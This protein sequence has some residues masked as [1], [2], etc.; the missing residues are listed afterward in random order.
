MKF[1]EQQVAVLVAELSHADDDTINRVARILF[2][3]RKSR[4]QDKDDLLLMEMAR[5]AQGYADWFGF[6]A[7]DELITERKILPCTAAGGLADLGYATGNSPD[8][9]VERLRKKFRA[10]EPEYLHRAAMLSLIV[11]S[12]KMWDWLPESERT[13]L[14]QDFSDHIEKWPET[15]YYILAHVLPSIRARRKE[16]RSELAAL[17]AKRKKLSE[18]L[19]RRWPFFQ[20]LP[21]RL[22]GRRAPPAAECH[23]GRDYISLQEYP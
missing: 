21:P 4:L 16:L 22:P 11:C 18:E 7:G 15:L 8:A 23:S 6:T 20:S 1:R 14:E 2:P 5:L 17:D 13:R 10:N 12:A 19:A 3:R 9:I